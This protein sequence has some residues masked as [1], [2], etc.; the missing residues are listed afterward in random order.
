MPSIALEPTVFAEL[1]GSLASAM[2]GSLEILRTGAPAL[3]VSAFLSS[4]LAPHLLNRIALQADLVLIDSP[5]LLQS[6]SAITLATEVDAILIVSRLKTL[7]APALREL[8]RVLG[9]GFQARQ[10]GFVVTNSDMPSSSYHASSYHVDDTHSGV[11]S[12]SVTI[13]N[14]QASER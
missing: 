10:L 3:D 7:N 8:A 6:S 14:K 5:P 2:P 4:D 1:E 11:S 13:Q 12:P 9:V